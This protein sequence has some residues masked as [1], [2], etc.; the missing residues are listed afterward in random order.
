MRTDL[1]KPYD[2]TDNPPDPS[3]LD[4]QQVIAW[5]TAHGA[6]QPKPMYIRYPFGGFQAPGGPA[7][8]LGFWILQYPGSLGIFDLS[9]TLNAPYAA[10]LF[11]GSLLGFKPTAAVEYEPPAPP[12]APPA[13][14]VAQPDN[15]VGAPMQPWFTAVGSDYF[16]AKGD[17]SQVG[18][19]FPKP[20]VAGEPLYQKI[21]LP[22]PWAAEILWRRIA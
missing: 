16:L 8:P 20:S 3:S 18:S 6:P 11:L 22:T 14:P 15:P 17:T 1:A 5:M 12:P 19:T 21:S 13:P 9:V 10:L 4:A 2:L 7:V